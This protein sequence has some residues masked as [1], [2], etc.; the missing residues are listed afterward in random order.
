MK[1]MGSL[2]EQDYYEKLRNEYAGQAMARMIGSYQH[3]ADVQKDHSYLTLVAFQIAD[4]MVQRS[5][6]FN[7]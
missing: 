5:K 4:K 7:P 3:P 2:E 1:N 6:T